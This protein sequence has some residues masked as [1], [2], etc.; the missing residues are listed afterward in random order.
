[1]T[2]ESEQWHAKLLLSVSGGV[3]G[4]TI[5]VLGLAFKPNTDDLREAPSITV[6]T[7]LHDMGANVRVFDPAAMSHARRSC[8]R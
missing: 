2:T 7:A 1:M 6:I 3:R 8:R 4:K 5:A